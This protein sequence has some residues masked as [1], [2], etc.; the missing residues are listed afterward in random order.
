MLI[1]VGD[2][3]LDAQAYLKRLRRD[4]KQAKAKLPR[5]PDPSAKRFDLALDCFTA[6]DLGKLER[7]RRRKGK[8][9]QHDQRLAF[10]ADMS[11]EEEVAAAAAAAA[12]AA[13][14]LLF[15]EERAAAQH[16]TTELSKRQKQK[17]KRKAKQD[18]RQQPIETDEASAP[19][20]SSVAL[21]MAVQEAMLAESTALAAHWASEQEA[22]LEEARAEVDR[23]HAK[24][25]GGTDDEVEFLDDDDA[26]GRSTDAA[27]AEGTDNTALG[28]APTA[29]AT[30][31][32]RRQRADSP[33]TGEGDGSSGER[34]TSTGPFSSA[35]AA[36]RTEACVE[37]APSPVGPERD[38]ATM[39]A[40]TD[41][42]LRLGGWQQ[43]VCAASGKPYYWNDATDMTQWDRPMLLEPPAAAAA[44]VALPTACATTT[45]SAAGE[46]ERL[47][48]QRDDAIAEAEFE[49]AAL[50]RALADHEIERSMLIQQR[51]DAIAEAELERAA[52]RARS[53]PATPPKGPDGEAGRKLYHGV[54][55][56][57]DVD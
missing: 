10:G 55:E 46:I 49:R 1:C 50:K 22:M 2:Q 51:D 16:A 38:D 33:V 56:C 31:E 14:E 29:A 11:K 17:Q 35:A 7:A 43:F 53:A 32:P 28:I 23:R 4:C 57:V 12:A 5:P 37:S 24:Q 36:L 15:A 44:A 47:I 40:V 26:E 30:A 45:E 34:A 54:H 13:D 42:A 21:S 6:P 18:K 3:Q 9:E 20:S 41:G 8:K 25:H 39:A 48:Q 19:A 52:A 27:S